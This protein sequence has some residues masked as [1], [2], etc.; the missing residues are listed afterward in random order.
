MTARAWKLLDLA[1]TLAALL[2]CLFVL[3]GCRW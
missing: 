3:R 1:A 2:F